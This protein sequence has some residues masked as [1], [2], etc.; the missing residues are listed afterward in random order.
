MASSKRIIGILTSS[1]GNHFVQ[2]LMEGAHQ[3]L[4]GLVSLLGEIVGTTRKQL[5]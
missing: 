2:R 1:V 4:D 5:A 3:A